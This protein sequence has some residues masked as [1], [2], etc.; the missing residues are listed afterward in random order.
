MLAS[1][2]DDEAYSDLWV[3]VL[4]PGGAIFYE[5]DELD[6]F[7]TPG[8][9]INQ[10]IRN[11]GI[12]LDASLYDPSDP[13]HHRLLD[14]A[15][16]GVG[17]PYR[18]IRVNG[19]SFSSH[20]M[21]EA[22]LAARIVHRIEAAGI[23]A[24]RILEL[25]G[26]YG[27]LL[28]Q[29]RAYYGDRMTLYA[30]DLPAT[31][32]IQEWYLRS[33]FPGAPSTHKTTA[34]PVDY[35]A[36]GLNF[37]NGHVAA[38]QPMPLDVAVSIQS[39]SDMH[40]E[41]ANAYIRFIERNISPG[42]VFYSMNSYA[43]AV[44][45][46]ESTEYGFDDYW[47][48]DEAL[49]V[50]PFEAMCG[51]AVLAIS[52][53]RTRTRHDARVRRLVLRTLFNAMH[54]NLIGRGDPVAREIVAIANIADPDRAAAALR[55]TLEPLV[56]AHLE[57]FVPRLQEAVYVPARYFHNR[58]ALAA[59]V[60]KPPDR[61][62]QIWAA[63]RHLE[64]DLTRL[65][66]DASATGP[67]RVPALGA[68]RTERD[69]CC[70]ELVSSLGERALPEF[71]C[72]WI[73]SML[74]ALEQRDAAERLIHRTSDQIAAPSAIW[75]TRFA[76]LLESFGHPDRA[77]AL[78]A[79]LA[80]R[81]DVRWLEQLK[82]AEILARLQ[83]AAGAA[84]LVRSVAET[85]AYNYMIPPA[86]KTA[87]RVGLTDVALELLS[88]YRSRDRAGSLAA[89]LDV[90]DF[91]AREGLLEVAAGLSGTLADEV[92]EDRNPCGLR[93]ELGVLRLTCADAAEGARLVAAA[94]QAGW[95]EH[96]TMGK[97]GRL[98]HKAGRHDWAE[99]CLERAFEIGPRNV[100]QLRW[101][102]NLRCAAG[103]WESAARTLDQAATMAPHLPALAA[104][105]AYCRLPTPVR[106]AGIFGK[107]QYVN[108]V[109]QDE[110]GHYHD[111]GVQYK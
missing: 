83:D 20:F 111:T 57:D 2:T 46:V 9:H 59:A 66:V 110:A 27:T 15:E 1:S 16:P 7:L 30:A 64:D 26:G 19:D 91:A 54:A 4:S 11:I 65:M 18:H 87:L 56:G 68:L 32:A 78:L 104:R 42:G 86:A 84:G 70:A 38:S 109:F 105:A 108:Y 85:C 71:W 100:R 21:Y 69:R 43:Q 41:T 73:A 5:P 48:L 33:C 63:L 101:L 75:M 72:G 22:A 24:P 102:G 95:D 45:A 36:G 10:W 103:M 12:V 88:G 47:Q 82:A 93:L 76:F 92:L 58:P 97:L 80:R 89:A 77:R 28:A 98:L 62:A 35:V 14:L 3:R 50:T 90:A 55:T 31:L 81:D 53:T 51:F 25:G 13:V 17:A 6:H 39:M 23:D 29:L 40:A 44:G 67:D 61:N 8:N 49:L 94:Q 74:F 79:D 34:A 99:L 96:F 107:R 60:S 106:D 52:M 37:V